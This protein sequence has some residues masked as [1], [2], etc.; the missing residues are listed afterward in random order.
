ML[1]VVSFVPFKFVHPMRVARMRVLTIAALL[2]WS[3]LAGVA[4]LRDLDPGPWVAGG[5]VAIA[6]YFLAI[7]LTEKH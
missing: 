5:L 2:L 6:L 1:A 3:V 4:L 7:G